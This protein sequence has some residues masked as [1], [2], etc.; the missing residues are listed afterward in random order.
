MQEWGEIHN[1]YLSPQ[2]AANSHE[3]AQVFTALSSRIQ[4][5]SNTVEELVSGLLDS[6]LLTERINAAIEQQLGS[7]LRK[8]APNMKPRSRPSRVPPPGRRDPASVGAGLQNE[9]E[10]E[11]RRADAELEERLSKQRQD[12]ETWLNKEKATIDRERQELAA[13]QKVVEKALNAATNRFT[14]ERESLLADFLSLSPFLSQLG[15]RPPATEEPR[16]ITADESSTVSHQQAPSFPMAFSAVAGLM[17]EA[18]FFERFKQHVADA[19]FRFRTLDLIAFHLSV[20]CGDLT[21]LED[22]PARA[23]PPCPCFTPKPL[24]VTRNI[25]WPWM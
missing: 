1:V 16:T 11:R 23:S 9:L 6:G 19:G 4:A 25:S 3:A 12:Y 22:C 21:V 20:K 13:K 10:R 17:D 5:Q 18:A 24:R 14:E 8:T 15:A 2:A 7:I